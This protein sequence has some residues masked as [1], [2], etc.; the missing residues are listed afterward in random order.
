LTHL[1][2]VRYDPDLTE[3]LST[4]LLKIFD[5]VTIVWTN[6]HHGQFLE[7]SNEC[8]E[9]SGYQEG[10]SR[11][12]DSKKISL[13]QSGV[14]IHSVIFAN[15]TFFSGHFPLMSLF[16]MRA[17]IELASKKK[18]YC[19]STGLVMPLSE[20]LQTL[21]SSQK[22]FSSWIFMIEGTLQQLAKIRFYRE[23]LNLN[24]FD[25]NIEPYLPMP[26]KNAIEKWLRPKSLMRGWYKASNVKEI[27]IDIFRRKRFAI[28]LELSLIQSLESQGFKCSC[29]SERISFLSK[30][31][32]KILRFSDRAYVNFLK[33]S[34][35][36]FSKNVVSGKL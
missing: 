28:Y 9:F 19:L 21:T 3:E 26:Y 1:I 34:L 18:D 33:L 27:S 10:L 16:M 24:Y 13:E 35:R 22:Y 23:G 29:I 36:F 6:S 31:Y 2:L 8:F 32:L 7:N 12:L 5:S 15:D 30:I 11:F 20:E 4:S 25:K 17:L 14:D